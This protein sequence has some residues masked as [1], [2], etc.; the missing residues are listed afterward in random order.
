[1]AVGIVN[2]TH[3]GFVEPAPLALMPASEFD[4]RVQLEMDL[5][6]FALR[7]SDIPAPG[8]KSRQIGNYVHHN[9]WSVGHYPRHVGGSSGSPTFFENGNVVIGIVSRSTNGRNRICSTT[10]ILTIWTTL[11]T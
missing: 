10:N 1:M 9:V 6:T 5:N 2:W 4:A 11:T 8:P 3:P 7:P